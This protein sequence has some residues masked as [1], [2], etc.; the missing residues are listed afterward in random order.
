MTSI[1]ARLTALEKKANED[2]PAVVLVIGD[3][4][5]PE[6]LPPSTVVL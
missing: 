5:V 6:N 1:G 3:D 4:P 2:E